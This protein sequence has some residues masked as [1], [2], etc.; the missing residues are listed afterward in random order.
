MVFTG[1]WLVEVDGVE[2]RVVGSYRAPS[3]G[4][5]MRDPVCDVPGEGAS[6]EDYSIYIDDADITEMLKDSIIDEIVDLVCEEESC[7][8]TC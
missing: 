2:F 3:R 7:E 4:Y 5:T 1:E 8:I 6:L